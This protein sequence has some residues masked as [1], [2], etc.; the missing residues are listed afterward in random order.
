MGITDLVTSGE[1]GRSQPLRYAGA[2]RL[3]QPLVSPVPLP[4]RSRLI[5]TNSR[6]LR[7]VGTEACF[8]LTLI[9]GKF[10]ALV[11]GLCRRGHPRGIYASFLLR[12]FRAGSARAFSDIV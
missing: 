8:L 9:K 6:F 1:R 11:S 12:V 5:A 3:P 4:G 7:I 2:A 10:E